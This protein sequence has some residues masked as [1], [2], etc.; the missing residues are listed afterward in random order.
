MP[1]GPRLETRSKA[2]R[3][4]YERQRKRKLRALAAVERSLLS[5]GLVARIE[6]V[7]EDKARERARRHR[8]PAPKATVYDLLRPALTE[9]ERRLGDALRELH[10]AA[11]LIRSATTA[12]YEPPSPSTRGKGD[13]DITDNRARAWGRYRDM[14]GAIPVLTRDAV[15][16]AVVFGEPH[17]D[18][19]VICAGLKVAAVALGYERAPLAD[20]A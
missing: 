19:A 6:A 11:G 8:R 4:T 2:Q 10:V 15:L 1:I 13:D 7:V 12:A 9:G 16:G 14:A 20:A 17:H 18:P 5:P 3:R